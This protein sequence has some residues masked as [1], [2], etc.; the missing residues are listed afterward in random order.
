MRILVVDDEPLVARTV[1]L[2]LSK[3][4]FDVTTV[5]SAFDALA[6]AVDHPPDLVLCDIDMPDCDGIALMQDLGHHLPLCPILVLTG[7]FSALERAS[8]CAALLCQQVRI[9]LKPCPPALL[10]RE[11]GS[12]LQHASTA[13]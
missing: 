4:G 13:A 5:N 9:L 11:A 2:V 6:S 12:L 10:L 8:V 7:S 3:N 1:S